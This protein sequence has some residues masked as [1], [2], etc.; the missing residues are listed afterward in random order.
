MKPECR[1]ALLAAIAKAR[2]WIDD[3]GLG[4]A[5]T[6]AEIAAREG[7]GER[8]VRLLAPLAFVAPRLVAAIADGTAPADLTVTGA[9]QV[10]SLR[11]GRALAQL[12]NGRGKLE[13]SI[14]QPTI[15]ERAEELRNSNQRSSVP[16]T[17]VPNRP[18]RIRLLA[19][20]PRYARPGKTKRTRPAP[21]NLNVEITTPTAAAPTAAP[22]PTPTPG[23]T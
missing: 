11:M 17:L 14:S 21:G 19:K 13:K 7:V 6:L 18:R 12:G 2:Q 9:C 16:F 20:G 1:D 4:R 8:Y 22:T 10:G 15:A 23:R 3:F 5:T